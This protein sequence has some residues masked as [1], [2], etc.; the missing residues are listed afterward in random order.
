VWS[1][2]FVLSLFIANEYFFF[3]KTVNKKKQRKDNLIWKDE[4][5]SQ[6]TLERWQQKQK[7]DSNKST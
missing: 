6:I 4:R 3:E 7:C 2:A 5:E 1:S